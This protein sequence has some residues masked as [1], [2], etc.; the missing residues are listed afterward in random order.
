ELR[1][2]RGLLYFGLPLILV[3]FGIAAW[4][5]IAVPMTDGT[6]LTCIVFGAIG[7]IGLLMCIL[8]FRF[9]VFFRSF[10]IHRYRWGRYVDTLPYT[11]FKA[12]ELGYWSPL[13]LVRADGTYWNFP[14]NDLRYALDEVLWNLSRGGVPVPD[15]IGLQNRFGLTS[16]ETGSRAAFRR[17]HP[18]R[19]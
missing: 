7:A 18:P 4:V 2:P 16:F 1:P 11:N 15:S 12:A 9:R 13:R 6:R 10:G 5:P 3:G 19:K 17:A 14:S 8:Y